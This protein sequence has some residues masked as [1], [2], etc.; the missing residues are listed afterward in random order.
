MTLASHCTAFVS[1]SSNMTTISFG[2]VPGSIA[3]PVTFMN[4][5]HTGGF[6]LG[7]VSYNAFDSLSF[8]DI[9]MGVWKAPAVPTVTVRVAPFFLMKTSHI[10]TALT[11]PPTVYPSG[12]RKLLI[13][14]TLP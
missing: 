11:V 12:K 3:V 4:T 13:W 8:A 2:S 7:K 14:H 5:L 9:I 6:I 10:S 1:W